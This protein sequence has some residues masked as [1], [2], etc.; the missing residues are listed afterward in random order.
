MH[1]A[2]IHLICHMTESEEDKSTQATVEGS[3]FNLVKQP[4]QNTSKRNY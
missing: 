2:F 3:K 1:E 4:A